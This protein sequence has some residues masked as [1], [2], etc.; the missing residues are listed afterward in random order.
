MKKIIFFLCFLVLIQNIQ[1]ENFKHK[2]MATAK[3][4]NVY[5]LENRIPRF[6]SF[7]AQIDYFLEDQ[8]LLGLDFSYFKYYEQSTIIFWEPQHTGL[9]DGDRTSRKLYNLSLSG[10]LLLE[11]G[12]FSPFFKL[13]IGLYIPQVIY[14]ENNYQLLGNLVSTK[15][16]YKKTHLGINMGIGIYYKVWKRW[17]LQLEGLVN[18]IFSL[19][20]KYGETYPMQ[21][22]TL[23]AGL[24]V[25]F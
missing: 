10:K 15:N 20:E 9:E 14:Y 6:T 19:N 13:G 12:R 5:L 4:G 16:N 17:G 25:I 7:G 3:V 23:N 22:V 1:A 21:Y 11:P 24:F 2:F 18:H 8:I